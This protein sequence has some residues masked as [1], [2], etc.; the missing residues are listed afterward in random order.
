MKWEQVQFFAV[1]MA[2][3]YYNHRKTSCERAGVEA[4]DL[5]QVSYFAFLN[6][7]KA[8]DPDSGY[9]FTTYLSRHLLNQWNQLIGLRT[10]RAQS[11]PLNNC[12][13][14]DLTF[15]EEE[16]D[17][18]LVEAI[19]DPAAEQAIQQATE[20]VYTG[21]LREALERCIDRLPE[22]KAHTIRER[23]FEGKTLRE[24]AEG[25]GV[26]VAYVGV[27]EQGGL[28]GL[29][30]GQN[31]RELKEWRED[32]IDSYAYRGGFGAFR[33]V[34]ASSVE[35]PVEKLSPPHLK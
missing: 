10:V 26:S 6:A 12:T 16:G 19:A 34:Q 4:D 2:Y 1:K 8:Y 32:I 22:K 35:R 18:L 5:I 24:V 30:G 11:E 33:A 27:L 23:Y 31:L 7:Q 13:S 3:R 25:M 14:L 9:K 15:G 17:C 29:R 21:Q 20:R 28:R